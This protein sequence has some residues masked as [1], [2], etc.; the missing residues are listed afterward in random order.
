M[1]LADRLCHHTPHSATGQWN[2]LQ[3]GCVLLIWYFTL[4]AVE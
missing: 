3:A 1:Q 4:L 2:E